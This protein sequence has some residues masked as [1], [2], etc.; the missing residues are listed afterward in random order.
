MGI[1]RSEDM[2]LYKFVLSKD[3]AWDI[4]NILGHIN[5]CHIIDMNKNVQSFRLPYIEMI[6]RCELSE[7]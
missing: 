3:D 5:T 6:K 4:I 2:Y 7:R 1:F